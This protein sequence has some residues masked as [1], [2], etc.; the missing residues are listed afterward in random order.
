MLNQ[1]LVLK[2]NTNNQKFFKNSCQNKK[3]F[4]YLYPQTKRKTFFENFRMTNPTTIRWFESFTL[5]S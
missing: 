1:D 2:G 3:K 4:L 5:M